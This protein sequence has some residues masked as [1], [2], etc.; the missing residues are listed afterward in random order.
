MKRAVAFLI[1]LSVFII[2]GCALMEK[3]QKPE[4][5]G[6][7]E[8]QTASRFSDLPLPA[9]FKLMGESSYAFESSGVRVAAMQYQGK[10]DVEQV[11]NFY[12]EQMP[13][14]NWNLL[15]VVQYGS[16][17]LNFDREN[18]TCII[19]LIPKGRT[20]FIKFS[21]GPKSQIPKKPI[22]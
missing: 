1:L 5:A 17:L 12:K 19:E 4:S 20:V 18:E 3:K 2:S 10:A 13:M 16:R 7:L 22:K 14:Y 11:L 9:G 6:L 15:N 21:L 8:P